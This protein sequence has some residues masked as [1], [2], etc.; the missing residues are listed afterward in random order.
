MNYVYIG[1]IVNTHG[2]K[3][4]LKLL[5]DFEYKEKVFKPNFVIYVDSKEYIIT[6]YRHHKIFDMITLKGFNDINEVLFLKG[7]KVYCKKE[8]LNL[9]TNEYLIQDLI[10][11]NL[12][13]NNEIKGTVKD[14]TLGK[15]P[16][17]ELE[18]NKYI[19]Y[20]D[21]FIEKI[22]TDKNEIVVKNCE[23][24]L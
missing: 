9:R 21:N 23:G 1:K 22:D 8:D 14:I 13:F 17:I 6:S 4:E 15:N 10:G 18:N 7:K 3:G 11:M 16:L 20:R 5:S 12:I 2:I 19:P 24:L